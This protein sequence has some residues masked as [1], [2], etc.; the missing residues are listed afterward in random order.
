L[1]CEEDA[2]VAVSPVGIDGEVVSGASFVLPG[3]GFECPDFLPF[4]PTASIV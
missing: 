1:I 3:A 2:A 4:A